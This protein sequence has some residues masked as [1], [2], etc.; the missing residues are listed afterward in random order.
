[1]HKKLSE[2][3]GA[4]FSVITRGYSM[5]KFAHLAYPF[6]EVF[7]C[8]QAHQKANHCSK[9]KRKGEKGKAK[10]NLKIKSLTWRDVGHFVFLS[11]NFD[12]F[13]CLSQNVVKHDASGRKASCHVADAFLTRLKLIWPISSLKISIMPKKFILG[14][15][16]KD[17]LKL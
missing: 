5:V 16:L 4:K 1:M 13:A 17:F 12:F 9:K 10:K 8:K 11:Q 6:F 3:F 2:K 15:K 14:K 7:N